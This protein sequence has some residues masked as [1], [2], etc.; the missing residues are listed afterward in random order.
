MRIME[1]DKK[2]VRELILRWIKSDQKL[3]TT[4]RDI[5]IKILIE[6]IVQGMSFVQIA[7]IYK[8][9]PTKVRQIFEAI[10]IRIEKRV[11]KAIADVLRKLNQSIESERKP[12]RQ[13]HFEFSRIYLN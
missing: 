3:Q 9:H 7:E 12:K 1:L 13:H 2:Q 10:L 4:L 8:A 11:S 6:R 5:Q